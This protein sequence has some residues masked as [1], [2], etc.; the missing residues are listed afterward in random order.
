MEILLR[1]GLDAILE[2]SAPTG[3]VRSIFRQ[4]PQSS[5]K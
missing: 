5:G 1:F 3:G 4:N 2:E